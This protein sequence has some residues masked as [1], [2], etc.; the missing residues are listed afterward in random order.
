MLAT[1]YEL[2]TDPET[3]RPRTILGSDGFDLADDYRANGLRS[4]AGTAHPRLPNRWEIVGPLGFVGFAW[5]DFVETM[6]AHAV[7]IIEETRRRGAV[8]VAVN[9]EAFESW[10][11]RMLTQGKAVHLYLTA[12]NPGLSTYFINS[13]SD[14][15]YHRPQTIIGSRR[16][17]RR[18]PLTDYDFQR[19]RALPRPAPLA[20][21]LSA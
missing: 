5:P 19:R 12:C 7:R 17:A 15:V 6:A 3:Y 2:W 10:H 11:D 14:T 18:S 16:F 4:Y 21:E 1:G 8:V 20:K 9:Q 13:Q